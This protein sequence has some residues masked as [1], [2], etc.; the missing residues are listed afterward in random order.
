MALKFRQEHASMFAAA[1]LGEEHK[2]EHH[3]NDVAVGLKQSHFVLKVPSSLSSSP[4]SPSSSSSI[5]PVSLATVP[6]DIKVVQEAEE[7]EHSSSSRTT[8]TTKRHQAHP[9]LYLLGDADAD[10]AAAAADDDAALS[11]SKQMRRTMT[12]GSNGVDQSPSW[13]YKYCC[14]LQRNARNYTRNYGMLMYV[15]R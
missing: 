1:A 7:E 13:L 5:T 4:S 14:L 8:T 6:I 11:T 15:G 10:A 12:W 9:A 2:D 3:S